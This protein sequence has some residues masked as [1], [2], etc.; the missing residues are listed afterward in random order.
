M[1]Y[2]PFKMLGQLKQELA[3]KGFM[4]D[5]PYQIFFNKYCL[6]YGFTDK[7][8]RGWIMSMENKGLLK[9]HDNGSGSVVNF[10]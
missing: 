7:T 3:E 5:I 6:F 1:G 4:K 9:I 2:N 10:V 8:A